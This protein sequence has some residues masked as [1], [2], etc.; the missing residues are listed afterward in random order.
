MQTD[1]FVFEQPTRVIVSGPSGCGKTEFMQRV[2][3]HRNELFS[4]VP[5][6]VIYTFK[7]AQPWFKKFPDVHFTQTIPEH[8]SVPSLLVIDD[9]VCDRTTLKECVSLFVRGSHHLNVSVFL[10]T[11]N[12]FEQSPEYR[13]MSL[14]ANQF[15]L[16]KTVRGMQQIQNLG[17]QIYGREKARHFMD[18]YIDATRPP[19][20][21]LLVDVSPTQDYR[22]RSHIFPTEE[23]IVYLV[24]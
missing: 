3:Q 17:R 8:F 24:E 10:L 11:Q 1:K 7:Y 13:T 4:P 6:R 14:N 5:Q 20:S 19:Y 2:I 23:E 18:A 16:F 21:Y 12:L 9:I 15:V 22:L